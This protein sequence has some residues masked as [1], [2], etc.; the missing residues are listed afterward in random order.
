[1]K[2]WLALVQALVV[3]K[4]VQR[5]RQQP[6]ELKL[7]VQLA[8][9]LHTVDADCI[10]DVFDNFHTDYHAVLEVDNVHPVVLHNLADLD[11]G[12]YC[13]AWFCFVDYLLVGILVVVDL[14]LDLEFELGLGFV[15]VDS[16]VVCSG[17]FSAVHNLADCSCYGNCFVAV[18][19][20]GLADCF[21]IDCCSSFVGIGFD[22][23][24]ADRQI[25]FDFV[26]KLAGWD[27]VETQDITGAGFG[28]GS[29]AVVAVAVADS[30]PSIVVAVGPEHTGSTADMQQRT[31]Y[32]FVH[33]RHHLA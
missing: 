33:V 14:E 19:S 8:Q 11:N 13:M 6:Q 22:I 20:V 24:P 27:T 4:E 15:V 1:M 30:K 25:G 26:R 17:S 21:G 5:Q 9:H 29:E 28:T 31:P 23:D 2:T 7:I 32:T 12:C 3:V 16:F 10:D 18:Q